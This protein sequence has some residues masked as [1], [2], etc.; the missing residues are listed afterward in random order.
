MINEKI[1]CARMKEAYKY[2]G[3]W[4]FIYTGRVMLWTGGW[5]VQMPCSKLPRKA[6]GLLVEHMA[7]IPAEGEAY[8]VN[9]NND[10]LMLAEKAREFW[11]KVEL[12]VEEQRPVS[13]T[14]LTYGGMPLWQIPET[15]QILAFDPERAALIEPGKAE[16]I[17]T[18][19]DALYARFDNILAAIWRMKVENEIITALERGRWYEDDGL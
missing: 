18:D 3:Y 8:W 1:L 14:P 10:Q 5:A 19:G 6:L 12:P 11:D 9:K 15:K 13:R 4:V 17:Y 2:G 7:K 16:D